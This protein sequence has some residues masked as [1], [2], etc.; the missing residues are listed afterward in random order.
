MLTYNVNQFFK[1]PFT[2][3]CSS[4]YHKMRLLHIGRSTS[5]RKSIA[6][7]TIM[8][9]A[10]VVAAVIA[11]SLILF[12]THEAQA[13]LAGT[14]FP[15][16]IFYT[17]RSQPDYAINIPFS[18]EGKST[19]E[20]KEISIPTGMT[21]IWFNN[22]NG[23][24]TITTL[25]NNTYSP[26]E[27][28]DSGVIVQNGGS[29]IHQFN[30]PGRYVYFDQFNPSVHGIINVGSAIEQGKNFNMH[31]GGISTIPF[32]PNKAQSVV[33]SFVPKTVKFPPV[34]SLTY[35]VTI[36]N[37][38]GKPL[39]SHTYEDSD[40]ILDLELIPIHK[41]LKGTTTTSTNATSQKQQQEFTTWG[42]DFIGQEAIHSDGVFHISGPVLVENSPYS[43]QVSI[44]AISD[45][46][47][48]NPVSETFALPQ[49]I[50]K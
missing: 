28:I 3:I 30:H 39:Y 43:I 10:L 11:S 37:A 9:T 6:A 40:G 1:H 42:P 41:N 18:S 16:P 20:P 45:R 33:L 31:I 13:Q 44:A 26:P 7:I 38:T 29:F 22:D 12:R 49:N 32:N 46:E 25:R 17:L 14:T 8:I 2:E 34:T 27:T 47:L 24:H 19:F 23:Q 15:P 36:L 21:V 48:Q 4:D 50:V 5:K 35:N